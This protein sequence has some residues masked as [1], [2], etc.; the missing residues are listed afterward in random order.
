MSETSH[1]V[2]EGACYEVFVDEAVKEDINFVWGADMVFL[3]GEEGGFE[4]FAIVGME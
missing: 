4:D 1:L 3:D 2:G